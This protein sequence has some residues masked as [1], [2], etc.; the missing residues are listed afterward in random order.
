MT[1]TN[2]TL[3]PSRE[4]ATPG[5]AAAPLA[6]PIR[7]EAEFQVYIVDTGNNKDA[8]IEAIRANTGLELREARFLTEDAPGYIRTAELPPIPGV[9]ECPC[10]RLFNEL[11]SFANGSMRRPV[12]DSRREAPVC[13]QLTFGEAQAETFAADLRAAGASVV[14]VGWVG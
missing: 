12:S 13:Q 1:N 2:D 8:V 7:P 11:N 5:V 10:V 6:E 3:G 9:M 4:A 14:V